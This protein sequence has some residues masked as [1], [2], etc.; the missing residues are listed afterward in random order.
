MQNAPANSRAEPGGQQA[1]RGRGESISK[2]RDCATLCTLAVHPHQSRDDARVAETSR[3]LTA[4]KGLEEGQEGQE[5]HD[6]L[7]AVCCGDDVWPYHVH[8]SIA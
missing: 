3:E 6:L 5:V 4:L 2:N 8:V 7:W 1:E